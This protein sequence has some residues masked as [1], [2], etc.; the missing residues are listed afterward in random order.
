MTVS[1][2]LAPC[3]DLWNQ[4]ALTA[5]PFRT[6][7]GRQ[8]SYTSA[9]IFARVGAEYKLLSRGTHERAMMLPDS[10]GYDAFELPDATASWLLEALRGQGGEPAAGS[11][12]RGAR[13]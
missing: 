13:L 11:T 2:A 8:T 7:L 10:P 3:P 4:Y 6:E 12:A 5:C 9:E 1:G